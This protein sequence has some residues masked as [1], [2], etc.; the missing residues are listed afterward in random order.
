MNKKSYIRTKKIRKQLSNSLIKYFKP[1]NKKVYVY[2]KKLWNRFSDT[3]WSWL[4]GFFEG[5]GCLRISRRNHSIYRNKEIRL[6]ISQKDHKFLCKLK[7]Q[8]Q[9][10]RVDKSN[11]IWSFNFSNKGAIKAF[12]ERIQP[13]LNLKKRKEK[14][15][16]CLKI[17]K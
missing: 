16:L 12:L 5:E 13:F 7:K 3:Y 4:T 2:Y 14:V 8:L 11:T 6:F 15:K 10:G 17:L 9:I 1:H